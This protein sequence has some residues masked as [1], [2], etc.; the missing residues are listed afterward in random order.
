L[1][2]NRVLRFAVSKSKASAGAGAAATDRINTAVH[3]VQG[4][5]AR[6][7]GSGVLLGA[8]A[9]NATS[10]K[11]M[12][13][14]SSGPSDAQV[15]A[16]LQLANEFVRSDAV[17]Q[18]GEVARD[19]ADAR[20]AASVAQPVNHTTLYGAR[21]P[22]PSFVRISTVEIADWC[23]AN[24]V[25]P[26]VSRTGLI[27][28]IRFQKTEYA[29]DRRRFSVVVEI[30]G[31]AQSAANAP[32]AAAAVPA[33]ESPARRYDDALNV[34]KT[35][36]R[37]LDIALPAVPGDGERDAARRKALAEIESQVLQFKNAAYAAGFVSANAVKQ[38]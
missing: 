6:V 20:H 24:S 38:V 1:H 14:L 17:V 4:A 11:L 25:G 31:S 7:L 28:P 35:A 32:A 29:A 2:S 8:N 9:S 21:A 18:V 22:P 37:L 34:Q 13:E 26:H 10:G 15:A 12:L 5:F 33:A 36:L 3:V 23:L 30:D 27:G 16:A 19:V